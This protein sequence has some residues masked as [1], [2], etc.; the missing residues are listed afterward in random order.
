[1]R[2]DT[3]QPGCQTQEISGSMPSHVEGP[4]LEVETDWAKTE[5]LLAERVK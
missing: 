2:V 5:L 4:P 1:M 3:E